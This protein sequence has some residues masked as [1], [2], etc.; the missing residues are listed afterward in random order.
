M[1]SVLAEPSIDIAAPPAPD[2]VSAEARTAPLFVIVSTSA[3]ASSSACQVKSIPS[4]PILRL[5][6]ST[7][8]SRPLSVLIPVAFA[9]AT[10]LLSALDCTAWPS[11]WVKLTETDPAVASAVAIKAPELVTSSAPPPVSM[12]L[13][14]AF[15]VALV[16]DDAVPS[17][18]ICTSAAPARVIAL[19]V[20]VKAPLLAT[21]SSPA[22][23]VNSRST[24]TTRPA[25]LMSTMTLS[26]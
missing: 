10:A 14:T 12:P 2:T 3:A 1:T 16:S 26:A 6:F 7:S 9:S 25:L 19:A 24:L 8:D 22:A 15:A 5:E 4:E 17:V 11:G 18:F 13:V 20:A 21:L 23:E